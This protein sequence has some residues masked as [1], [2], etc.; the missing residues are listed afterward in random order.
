MIVVSDTS[1]ISNLL[2]IDRIYI[3]KDLFSEVT[4]P[5]AVDSEILELKKF[6]VDISSYRN[7]GW[8]Q[9]STPSN[10]HK[11][12]ALERNLDEGESQAIALAI[13]IKCDLLLIDERIGTKIARDEGLNTIG[14]IGVL[15]KAKEKG[16]IPNL[17]TVLT[18]LRTSAGFWIG[19]ALQE[20]ILKDAGEN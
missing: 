3:L 19:D 12:T 20:R 15:I 11:V 8:I 18:E 17:K 9:V 16:L 13:E 1:P 4:I 7:A 6:N 2:I 5:P 14:L 10:I